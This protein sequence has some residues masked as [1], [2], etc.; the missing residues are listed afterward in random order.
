MSNHKFTDRDLSPFAMGSPLS[1]SFDVLSTR[2]RART[3]FTTVVDIVGVV[4]SFVRHPQRLEARTVCSRWNLGVV[5]AFWSA[6]PLVRIKDGELPAFVAAFP[7]VKTL[8]LRGCGRLS[9]VGVAHLS[10]FAGMTMLRLGGG[11]WA[12]ANVTEDFLA[13]VAEHLTTIATLDLSDCKHLSLAGLTH[14]A[15]LPNLTSIKL[16]EARHQPEGAVV[17]LH[18]AK[19]RLEFA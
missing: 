8:D 2:P 7:E 13:A 4:S 1:K 6:K 10:G 15:R 17:F 9:A 16:P 19:P 12:G 11:P 5:D 3:P 14:V 18:Q